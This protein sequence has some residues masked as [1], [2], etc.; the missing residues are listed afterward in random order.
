[1]AVYFERQPVKVDREK[2]GDQREGEEVDVVRPEE[3]GERRGRGRGGRMGR[4]G[5]RR[6]GR[7]TE[8]EVVQF[9]E[10]DD[11]GGWRV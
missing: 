8:G 7:G 6:G 4:G 9:G 2:R 3:G 10:E 5:G 11:A 1:M